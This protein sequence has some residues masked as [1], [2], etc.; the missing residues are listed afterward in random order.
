MNV[1]AWDSVFAALIGLSRFLGIRSGRAVL[2]RT[3]LLG[4]FLHTL[5]SPLLLGTLLCLLYSL[6]PLGLLGSLGLP[7]GIGAPFRVGAGFKPWRERRASVSS[8]AIKVL[9]VSRC[10][11]T[12]MQVV[13]APCSTLLA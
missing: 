9:Y 11:P 5:R 4:A 6:H 13:A 3:T 1:D 7:A 8:A 10:S 12:F 2:Y